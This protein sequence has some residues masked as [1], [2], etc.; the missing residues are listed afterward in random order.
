MAAIII[1]VTLDF[2]VTYLQKEGN[3]EGKKSKNIK[4]QKH[5]PATHTG[6]SDAEPSLKD[7]QLVIWKFRALITI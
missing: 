6:T 7:M 5:M 4:R 2:S 1:T 3:L